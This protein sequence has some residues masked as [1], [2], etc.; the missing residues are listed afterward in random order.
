[1]HTTSCDSWIVQQ[2]WFPDD[3]FC[4]QLLTHEPCG[5]VLPWLKK[6]WQQ[7]GYSSTFLCAS[8][9][10]S[11]DL[12][13]LLGMSSLQPA[14]IMVVTMDIEPSRKL[15]TRI[16]EQCLEYQGSYR[17]ILVISVQPKTTVARNSVIEIPKHVD[18]ALS[19]D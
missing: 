12:E 7:Q 13:R 6:V 10:D 3:V 8:E 11:I 14:S 5:A 18:S 2:Q 1:M 4:I 17:I 15:Y 9:I 16:L 19:T